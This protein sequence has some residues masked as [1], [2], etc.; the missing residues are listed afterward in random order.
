MVPVGT[1][2]IGLA[3]AGGK[4]LIALFLLDLA[5]RYDYLHVALDFATTAIPC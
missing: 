3:K 4:P 5:Q 2:A 1:S